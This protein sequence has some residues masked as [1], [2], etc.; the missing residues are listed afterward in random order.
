M[1]FAN[2]VTLRL[3]PTRVGKG[4]LPLESPLF[5]R[6][7]SSNRGGKPGRQTAF[8]EKGEAILPLL[9]PRMHSSRP[10][11]RERE[12]EGG[13]TWP[14]WRW[15]SSAPHGRER[16][17]AWPGLNGGGSR[18]S[19]FGG[20]DSAA[21]EVDFWHRRSLI[22]HQTRSDEE[23]LVGPGARSEVPL[24]L[25]LPPSTRVRGAAPLPYGST[26][27]REGGGI[28]RRWLPSG[29]AP[30]GRAPLAVQCRVAA[31]HARGSRKDGWWWH[32]VGWRSG[33]EVWGGVDGEIPS[34]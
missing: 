18:F 31:R 21:T 10:Q 4:I 14:R 2:D 9:S 15:K 6:G 26:L 32:G 16:E 13:R 24:S 11:G 7:K 30:R 19:G 1:S 17:K 33:S 29:R 27:D 25:H 23:W 3:S 12:K 34:T 8:Q 5:T 22:W 20:V 28:R